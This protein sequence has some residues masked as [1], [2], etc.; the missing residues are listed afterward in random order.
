MTKAY[1]VSLKA[2]RLPLFFYWMP[3]CQTCRSW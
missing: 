2:D 3:F 1:Y